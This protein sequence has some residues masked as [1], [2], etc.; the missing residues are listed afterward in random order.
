V[1]LVTITAAAEALGV[2]P[3][4]MRQ[5]CQDGRVDGAEKLGRDWLIPLGTD[6]RPRVAEAATTRG[7]R[8][9]WAAAATQ[10][11]RVTRTRPKGR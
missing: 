1:K 9:R 8:P 2:S 6:G 4:R 5:L 10:T 11:R 3:V 7:P